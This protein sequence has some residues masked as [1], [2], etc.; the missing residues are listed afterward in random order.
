M[1]P[2]DAWRLIPGFGAFRFLSFIL[3][4]QAHS[5]LFW[6]LGANKLPD[7]GGANVSLETDFALFWALV[8]EWLPD[9]L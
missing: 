4:R 6:A 5:E 1:S 3:H 8:A 7:A 9:G 2:D